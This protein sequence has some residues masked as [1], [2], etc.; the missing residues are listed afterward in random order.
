MPLIPIYGPRP[1]ALPR[2]YRQTFCVLP[3][4]EQPLN[5]FALPV[6]LRHLSLN[7][8]APIGSGKKLAGFLDYLY[9]PGHRA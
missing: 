2:L 7:G 6:L 9:S 8:T 1:I 3:C 4:F 5:R